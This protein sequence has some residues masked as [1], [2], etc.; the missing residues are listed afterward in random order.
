MNEILTLFK[1]NPKASDIY[2]RKFFIAVEQF[3]E[4]NSAL[5]YTSV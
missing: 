3:R 4:W 2:S 5:P 1:L